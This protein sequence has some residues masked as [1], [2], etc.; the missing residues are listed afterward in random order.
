MSHLRIMVSRHSAFYSPL[1]VTIAA[2]FL[3]KVGL[4]ATYYVVG[5]GTSTVDEVSSRR[6]DIGQA[7]VSASWSYLEKSNPPPVAHFAQINSRDGFIIASRSNMKQFHWDDLKI[8]NFLYVHG[9]QPEAMLRYGLHKKG[10]ELNEIN[11]I[12]S[13]GGETMVKQWK[14]GQGD[15]FHEQGAYPQQLEE[16][17]LGH[18]VGSV[19]EAVG[20]VAFSSLICRWDWLDTDISRRFSEAYANAREWVNVSD[21]IEVAETE[22]DYFPNMSIKAVSS[23]INYYQKLGTWGGGTSIS[24]ELYKSALDVFEF[25]GLV[26]ARHSYDDVVVNPPL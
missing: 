13:P 25:S 20:P 3:E 14:E 9:G 8:G 16:E 19:G 12:E 15:Y 6:M 2:G 22:T 7:A 23:A 17:G 11:G 26:S 21:P 24:T 5:E 18:I 1:I 4:S 10:V